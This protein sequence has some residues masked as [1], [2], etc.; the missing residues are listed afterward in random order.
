MSDAVM[1]DAKRALIN[2]PRQEYA[3]LPARF[4]GSGEIVP[5]YPGQAGMIGWTSF[6]RS[7]IGYQ[8]EDAPVFQSER[9]AIQNLWDTH[10]VAIRLDY[11][12][13]E[14]RWQS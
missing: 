7:A 12:P 4:N 11:N 3:V 5:G 2:A 10:R 6:V 1:S 9:S 13:S 14:P 8:Y